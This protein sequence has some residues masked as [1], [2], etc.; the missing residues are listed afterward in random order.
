M[1]RRRKGAI[2]AAMSTPIRLSLAA[3][4]VV[5]LA[6]LGARPSSAQDFDLVLTGGRV[7]DP[8]SGLDAVR[9]IGVRGGSIAAVTDKSISGRRMIDASGLVVAPGFIDLHAHGQDPASNR[10]QAA[11]GVTTA[12]ECEIGVWPVGAWLESRRGRAIVNYG[13]TAGHLPARIK[14]MHGIDAR[15][16]ALPT[17]ASERR[18]DGPSDPRPTTAT[19]RRPPEQIDQLQTLIEQGLDEGALGI[20]MG[21]T[22]TPAATQRRDPARIRDRRQARRHGV[23]PPARQ[24]RRSAGS[25]LLVRSRR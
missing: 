18:D 5:Q 7:I 10:L 23:R 14:L 24:L 13:A 2:L 12:L 6:A 9:S 17:K 4:L 21:I 16:T 11:D 8:A 25:R 22:Y 20:G 3:A 19:R 1:R 15:H